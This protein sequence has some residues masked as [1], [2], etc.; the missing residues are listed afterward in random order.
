MEAEEEEA[1]PRRYVEWC[2][3]SG[4]IRQKDLAARA[5]VT[6][7]TI[8]RVIRGV[9]VATQTRY[10]ALFAL[11]EVRAQRELPEIAYEDVCWTW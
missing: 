2:A 5:G 1:Q 9:R 3:R 6:Q 11:N 4:R 7:M 8:S 10:L